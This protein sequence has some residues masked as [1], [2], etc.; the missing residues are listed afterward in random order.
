MDMEVDDHPTPELPSK[1]IFT[2]ILPRLPP[3]FLIKQCRRVC[4]SWSTLIRHHSFVTAYRNFQCRKG[5]TNFLLL[6]ESYL[7]SAQLNQEGNQTPVTRL[8]TIYI[9]PQYHDFFWVI[10]LGGLL[11]IGSYGDDPVT[12]SNPSTGESIQLPHEKMDLKICPA[13]YIG[14]TPFTNEYKV[15]QILFGSDEKGDPNITLNIF[16]LGMDYSWRPLKV[17]VGDLPFDLQDAPFDRTVTSVCLHGAIHWLHEENQSILVFDLGDKAFRVIPLPQEYDYTR[18]WDMGVMLSFTY[19]VEVGG[20][21]GVFVDNSRKQDIA[22]WILKDYQNHVWVKETIPLL[23]T[24]RQYHD[25]NLRWKLD[26]F[27]TIGAGDDLLIEVTLFGLS[28]GCDDSPPE[29][30]LYNMKSKHER[31][32]DFTFPTG[33]PSVYDDPEEPMKLITSY[34]DSI[35][36]LKLHNS[37]TES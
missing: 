8:S 33:M 12:I 22:L 5:T 14:F 21:L 19:I 4:K 24:V 29:Y 7:F 1:I 25:M 27:G 2:H 9:N 31:T 13:C 32:L 15:L 28:P 34:E 11:V 23:S 30:Y 36:P 20:C 18:E 6:R 35:I 17:D 26:C 3:K 10:S 37:V 16:T